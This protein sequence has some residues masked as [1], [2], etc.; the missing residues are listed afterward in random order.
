MTRKKAKSD[1]GSGGFFFQKK[2][3]RKSG[4]AISWVTALK[5]TLSIMFLTLLAAGG[6]VGLIYLERYVKEAAAAQTPTG[7]LK[8]VN[9][10]AW[11]NQDWIDALVK[12]AGGK[13]FELDDKSARQV[14]RRLEQLSWLTDVRVQ[15][16]PEFL[17]VTAIYRRPIAIVSVSR[18]RKFYLDA[19]M[20]VL[21]YIPVSAIPVIEITGLAKTNVSEPGQIWLADDAKAA[22]ELLNW[23]YLMDVHFQQE[24][25]LPK[26][27]IDEIISVDVSNFAARKSRSAPNIVLNVK[28]GTRILWGAAWGQSDVY[29]EASEKIKVARL[30]EYFIDHGYTLQG[31]A[32]N[33]ELRWLEDSIPRPQ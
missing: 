2:K 7:S 9:S 5:I 30:Y 17:E 28:D 20:V 22:V 32:K 1:T 31:S 24:Q 19:D 33:I 21:D 6:A 4:T 29:L 11:L 18:T 15:T 26:P 25:K 12:A 16:T 13:R 23:L 14:A 27:L 3:R 10:P 8:L